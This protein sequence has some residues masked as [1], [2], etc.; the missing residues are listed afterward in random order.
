M[1]TDSK[2]GH[3]KGLLMGLID[4]ELTQEESIEINDHLIRC[5]D[6]RD[7][8]EQL[9]RSSDRLETM[10]FDEPTDEL[11]RQMWRNPFNRLVRFGGIVMLI[12]GYLGLLLYGA[13][14]FITNPDEDALPRVFIAAIAIG[15]VILLLQVVLE[16]LKSYQI[17][18]Y[19]EVKR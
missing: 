12:G 16:R 11:L 8:Y 9:R 4:Q 15:F 6:C 3:F 10:S 14:E 19:K 7:E 1:N 2:C 18:P 5:S 13:F 17:D